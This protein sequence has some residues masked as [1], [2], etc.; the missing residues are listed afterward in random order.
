MVVGTW[1]ARAGKDGIEGISNPAANLSNQP[2][3]MIEAD[4]PVEVPRYGLVPDSGGPGNFAAASPSCASSAFSRRCASRCAATGATHPPYGME[5]GRPG[6]PSSHRSSVRTAGSASCRPCR[7]RAS[8]PGPAMSSV[9]PAPAGA[10]MGTRSPAIRPV[11]ADEM[12]E[13]KMT[14]EQAQRRDYGVVIQPT[15]TPWTRTAHRG[16]AWREDPPM[17]ALLSALPRGIA[18][19]N[20]G[21]VGQAGRRRRL[22]TPAAVLDLDLLERE[23]ARLLAKSCRAP[24]SPSGPMP[25]RINAPRSRGARSWRARSASVAPSPANCWRF[26]RRGVPD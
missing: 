21:L 1:G 5:G 25:N 26:G 20:A 7:W 12:L 18:D 9:S 17:S 14:P 6:S 16:G 4:T 13:G 3:E 22:E 2:I 8:T 15:G 23:L 19:W 11:L 10:A 24:A